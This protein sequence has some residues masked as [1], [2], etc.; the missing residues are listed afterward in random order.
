MSETPFK[1]LLLRAVLREVYPMVIRLVA[2]PDYLEL[3]DFDDAFHAVL[4]WDGGIGYVFQVQGQQFNSF[5]RRTR[6]KRLRDFGFHGQEKFLY[7]LGAMDQWEWEVR[8]IDQQPG[9]AEDTTPV[10]VGGRGATPPQY[11]GG[12]TGYRLMLKRQEMGEKMFPPAEV[13]TVIRML[14]TA[15]PN[16]PASSWEVLRDV[17]AKSGVSLDRRLEESGPLRP[18]LFSLLEA[19]ERLAKLLQ[20]RRLA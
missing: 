15:H 17:I 2:V 3:G 6:A 9:T 5:R 8:V 20:Y 10:C 14:T 7:T 13:E 1:R 4:G 12:P 16:G 11:S 19:N 18:E